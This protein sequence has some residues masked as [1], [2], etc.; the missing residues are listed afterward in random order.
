MTGGATRNFGKHGVLLPQRGL[1]NLVR[2]VMH[3]S[4]GI[5]ELPVKKETLKQ[6]FIN[7]I[8]IILGGCLI[9][10]S[11]N[12]F[13]QSNG[14]ALGDFSGIGLL[15]NYTVGFPIGAFL[16]LANVPLLF[17]CWKIWDLS[18]MLKSLIGVISESIAVEL[19]GRIPN[20]AMI[21][22]D[23]LL[24]AIYGGLIAGI[25]TGITL[26][27]GG[28]MGGNDVLA[29]ICE[30]YR[31]LSV[32][33]FYFVFDGLVIIFIALISGL[34]IALYSLVAVFIYSTIVNK[35]VDGLDSGKQT[36]IVS[37]K[38]REIGEFLSAETGRGFTY[39][40]AKGGFRGDAMDVIMCVVNRGDMFA[41]RK[42][43]HD[44]DPDAFM[45]ICTASEI[46]GRGFRK[47]EN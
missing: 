32:S 39:L 20:I 40:D 44:I 35:I 5:K 10:L 4:S 43:V 18:F 19:M 17:L 2:R 23:P 13:I 38:S 12:V 9:G 26:R 31:G 46:Y 28:T 11:I 36:F 27:A 21:Y 33:T 6:T 29:R 42:G 15:L 47:H 41:I 7:I 45:I 34:T 37:Q 16:F 25:G 30:K 1:S 8:I 14:L 24:P 3:A 22:E